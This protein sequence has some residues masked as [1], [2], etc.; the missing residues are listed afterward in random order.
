MKVEIFLLYCWQHAHSFLVYFPLFGIQRLDF[1][2]Q[3][4]PFAAAGGYPISFLFIKVLTASTNLLLSSSSGGSWNKL[5]KESQLLKVILTHFLVPIFFFLFQYIILSEDR[6]QERQ[7]KFRDNAKFDG[8][9]K[10]CHI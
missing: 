8:H 9:A 5:S 4:V 2:K 1:F 10:T 6:Q 3:Y 7:P